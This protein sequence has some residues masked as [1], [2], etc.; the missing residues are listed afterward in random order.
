MA[1]K[2][3]IEREKKRILLMKRYSAK[4]SLLL[5]E[6]QTEKN[7]NRKFGIHSKLQKLP[8]N[9]S[10]LRIRNRCWKTGRP[11]GVFRDFGLSR[12]VFREMAH[13]CLLPG[14]TKSSW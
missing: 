9:S 7:F 11:R 8:R 2:S 13:N 5:K 12:H 14:V 4:R 3:M 10:K 6:Y 1:K